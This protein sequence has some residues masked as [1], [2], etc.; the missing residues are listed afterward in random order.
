MKRQKDIFDLFRENQSKLNERP[1]P[2]AWRRL[3]SRLDAHRN[4]NR[5]SLYRQLFMVAAVIALV[6]LTSLLTVLADKN[7]Q[8]YQAD[9]IYATEQLNAPAP[10]EQQEALKI[11]EFSR[12]SHDRMSNPIQE[13]AARQK[14]IPSKISPDN[15][16]V[17]KIRLRSTLSE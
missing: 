9:N 10:A 8:Q 7:Q 13:G 17:G 11:A 16:P 12:K 14:L 3:E 6:A 4:R 2:Q 1:S 5:V 15:Q